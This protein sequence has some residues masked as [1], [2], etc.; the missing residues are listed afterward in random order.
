[1]AGNVALISRG[2][3]SFLDKSALARKAGAAAAVI[4]N[5][6]SGPIRGLTLGADNSSADRVVPTIGI[7]R[8]NGLELLQKLGNSTSVGVIFSVRSFIENIPTYVFSLFLI[9][10]NL[11]RDTLTRVS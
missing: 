2:S 3:C 7:S 1:V 6:A 5:D 9:P 11:R 4:Y 10:T 8:A